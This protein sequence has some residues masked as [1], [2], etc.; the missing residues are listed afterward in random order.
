MDFNKFENNVSVYTGKVKDKFLV[1]NGATVALNTK[2]TDNEVDI[3]TLRSDLNDVDEKVFILG[4]ADEN[5]NSSISEIKADVSTLRAYVYEQFDTE[6][7]G[8]TNNLN[9]VNSSIS[10]IKSDIS[11]LNS[12]ISSLQNADTSINTWISNQNNL[13]GNPDDPSTANTLYGMLKALKE[14]V[15]ENEEVVAAALVDLNSRIP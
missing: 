4:M 14:Q 10:G 11:T 12:S 8:I 13:V 6:S 1:I 7:T 5:I 2:V 3:S 15:D 9:Q